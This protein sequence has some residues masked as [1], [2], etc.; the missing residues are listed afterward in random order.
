MKYHVYT[1]FVSHGP[2]TEFSRATECFI[3][4]ARACARVGTPCEVKDGYYL[5]VLHDDRSYTLNIR[6]VLELGED[7]GLFDSESNILHE[8]AVEGRVL[9]KLFPQNEGS[10][11][12]LARELGII[13]PL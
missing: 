10:I 6:M 2:F 5:F 12:A 13:G 3:E 4:Y 11:L 8:P 9:E 7:V 1:S